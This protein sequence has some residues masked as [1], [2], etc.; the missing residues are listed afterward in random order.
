MSKHFKMLK[1]NRGAA[2]VVLF[3][4]MI[5]LS[6]LFVAFIARSITDNQAAQRNKDV[7]QATYLA[8]AGINEVKRELYELF[9]TYY[10]TQGRRTTAFSWFDD[11]VADP[12]NKYSAIPTNA[13]LTS[14]PGGSYT[15][16]V[17]G[18]DVSNNVPKDIT[19]VCTA[20]VNNITKTVTAVVQYTMSPSKVFDYSY[21]INNYG[22]FWGSTITSQGEIRS[23]GNFSFGSYH[24]KVNGDVYASINPEIGA[25]GTI[26]G[27]NYNDS[28]STYRSASGTTARPSNPTAD[29]QDLDGDGTNEE[30]P[31]ENGYDGSSAKY[32]A[33]QLL[34]MPYLG[35]LNYYKGLA[36]THNGTIKQGGATVVT[37]VLD[38]KIV[39]IGTDANPIEIDGPVVVTGDVLIKGK[40]SGQGTI[41]SGRNMH[42]I[43]SVQYVDG[44]SWTKPDTDPTGTDTVNE[45]KNFLGLAAKG[46]VIVG[47]Y[48]ESAWN[49]CKNYLK[50]S[51]TVPYK[52]DPQDADIG[53]VSYYS[54]GD[55]YF[56][57]DYTAYD[58]GTKSDGSNRRFYES[59]YDNTYFASVADSYTN[60]NR[61]DAVVY[62][63]HAFTGRIKNFQ[64][65]GGIISR[66][67]AI[68]YTNYIKMNYD[69]R[70]KDKG[71]D[72]YLPRALALPHVQYLTKN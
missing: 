22:W 54:G 40:V 8:E 24:P 20:Q 2:M 65:N 59:S 16:Q 48:T 60:M 39:L 46:N 28:L 56:N 17:T 34:D 23:N 64:M 29:P 43:G 15:V 42:I 3:M 57:G 10:I 11:L 68:I 50:P 49:S 37:N 71:E 52:V 12:T 58:G 67:E 70:A 1:N 21:F 38:D 47:D 7:I 35:D 27:T 13:T 26:S 19:L 63:N 32:P 53:Y 45:G 9:E 51:F 44:P 69:V 14:V 62:T 5:I 61:V 36:A 4:V 33:Q 31:Y 66:D 30:F 18:I 6:I 25:A 72:F 41:Y 55:A